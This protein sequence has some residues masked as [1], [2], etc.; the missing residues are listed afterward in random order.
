VRLLRQ[1]ALQNPVP[2][3]TADLRH[4]HVLLGHSQDPGLCRHR[5]RRLAAVLAGRVVAFDALGLP[6]VSEV[7]RE[8]L[9]WLPNVAV[10]LAVLVIGGV[11]ALNRCKQPWGL[12]F[13][14][15]R[16]HHGRRNMIDEFSYAQ[17]RWGFHPRA[18]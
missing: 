3:P 2:T 16:A 18:F 12:L 8:L 14:L 15:W 9:L 13:C 7:L 4:G 17:L 1:Q 5:H 10:A 6:A 11:A